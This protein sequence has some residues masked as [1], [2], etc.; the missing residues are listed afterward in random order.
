MPITHTPN[1]PGAL[2]GRFFHTTKTCP[3]GIR[4]PV[5]QGKILSAPKPDLLLVELFE[6]ILSEPSGQELWSLAELVAQK[7][8]LY[9]TAADMS[10]SYRHG[11]MRHRC[12]DR[13][14]N[15]FE[16]GA[17]KAAEMQGGLQ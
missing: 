5:Y 7:P 1:D 15:C 8:I 6:W 3:A 11:Q 4:I 17:L 10:F 9:D 14:E 16:I 2:V 12:N 13:D